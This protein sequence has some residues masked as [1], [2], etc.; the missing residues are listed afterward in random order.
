MCWI[1]MLILE[2]EFLRLVLVV[3]RKVGFQD[4]TEMAFIENEH[5]IKAVQSD[6]ADHYFDKGDFA[7][8]SGWDSTRGAR[9][10]AEKKTKN[11]L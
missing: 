10:D 1:I 4:P 7:R 3:I 9:R 2:V 5:K 6:R 8:G 11:K